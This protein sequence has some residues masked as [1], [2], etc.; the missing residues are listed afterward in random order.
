MSKKLP[1]ILLRS[2]LSEFG[3]H[4][5]Y[6][7]RGLRHWVRDGTWIEAHG[8]S[9][10]DDVTDVSA[11]I[12]Y[13][14]R[15]AGSAP[16]SVLADLG[17][18]GM[19][20]LNLREVS[21]SGL[22]GTGIE[23]GAGAMP[24]PVPLDC[25]VLFADAFSYAAL[26]SELYPGQTA[27]NLIRPDFVTDIQTLRGIA[28][29]SLDFVIAC[30]VIEHTT[31]PIA[32]ILACHRALKPGGKLVLVVPDM[33]RTFDREREVTTLAHLLEDYE[34]PSF[35]RDRTHYEEFYTKAFKIPQ[36]HNFPEYVNRQHAE[37]F[38]IHFHTWT[39]ES[40]SELVRHVTKTANWS[41]VWSHPTSAGDENIEFYF[42]LTK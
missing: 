42:V 4:V 12:I 2:P 36:D 30:H 33:E 21:A 26:S 27:H 5:F 1:G 9:W 15:H 35:T 32:A 19:V 40:F 3:A 41:D 17:K 10:P 20:S 14:Y 8:F 29:D 6:V 18:N 11:E 34:A 37:G 22:Y 13:S 31:N 38:S 23:F 28:D 24:F 16:L 39:F 25:N 7:D